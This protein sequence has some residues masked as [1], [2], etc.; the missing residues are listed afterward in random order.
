MSRLVLG[1]VGILVDPQRAEIQYLHA[2]A[3]WSRAES[4]PNVRLRTAQWEA[5]AD[6]FTA[7]ASTNANRAT[8]AAQ[9]AVLAWPTSCGKP[10]RSMSRDRRRRM[11]PT[12]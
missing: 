8:A 3:S 11:T 9:G 7:V 4:E 5:A 6:G 12:S 1:V 2:E 10:A